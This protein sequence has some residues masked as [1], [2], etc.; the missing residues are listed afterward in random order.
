MAMGK[1]TGKYTPENPPKGTRAA[2][3]NLGVFAENPTPVEAD[4]PYWQRQRRQVSEPGGV[5]L[6]YSKGDDSHTGR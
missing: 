4:D 2:Q 6:V 3:Y 1:P 5:K